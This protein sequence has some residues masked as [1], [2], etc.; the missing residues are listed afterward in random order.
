MVRHILVA[1]S[2][3][4]SHQKLPFMGPKLKLDTKQINVFQFLDV[5]IYNLQV[6]GYYSIGIKNWIH[7]LLPYIHE[8]GV[9]TFLKD[10]LTFTCNSLLILQISLS[11][12][13]YYD[14]KKV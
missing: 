8:T 4:Y 12:S 1:R 7:H 13:S 9:D 11:R 3:L 6:H 14:Q 10:H 5:V 2:A